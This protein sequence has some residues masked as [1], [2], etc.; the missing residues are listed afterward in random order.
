MIESI[1]D[2]KD[3]W[4]IYEL[5]AGRTMNE[6]LFEVKGEFYKGERI[7]MVHHSHFYHTLRTNLELLKDFLY[8]MCMALSLFARL[9]IVHGD[10][11]PDNIIID[12]DPESQSIRSL[13]VIDLGSAFLLNEEGRTIRNQCEFVQSTPEYLPPE[14]HNFL[15]KRFTQQSNVRVQDFAQV[16]FI[17]DVW[18]LGSILLEVL[19]GFP[20]W[21]S[22]KSRVLMLDGHSRINMGL[23][24]VAG[25][26][27]AKI[28]TKQ[29]QLFGSG[30]GN[31]ISVLKKGFDFSGNKWVNDSDFIDLFNQIMCL[32]PGKRIHP[33]EILE[34]GFMA[35]KMMLKAHTKNGN[36]HA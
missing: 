22:L 8:R 19:S 7:Y 28:M 13:K 31:L 12:Y 18:S 11:K 25:R 24:G 1:D 36:G 9:S 4:L 16:S 14:I 6:H 5:C 3:L 27:N 17:F 20:L 10:L 32:H 2:K 26:D 15:S 21:L 34:H 23:F 30:L 33:E 35:S 29:N